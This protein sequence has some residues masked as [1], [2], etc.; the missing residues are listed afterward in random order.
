[1]FQKSVFLA[2]KK[3]RGRADY[4]T[5]PLSTVRENV[6]AVHTEACE[7]RNNNGGRAGDQT[8]EQ[9]G[10]NTDFY[11]LWLSFTKSKTY[12]YEVAT[13]LRVDSE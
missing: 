8:R 2:F 10:R 13:N 9:H 1:L 6:L 11:C 4:S 3:N 7:V 12:R 5:H